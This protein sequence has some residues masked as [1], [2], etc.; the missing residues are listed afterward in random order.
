[1]SSSGSLIGPGVPAAAFNFTP[2]G[3]APASRFLPPTVR[4]VVSTPGKCFLFVILHASVNAPFS[5]KS[6]V[7]WIR[8][9]ALTSL[10]DLR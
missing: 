3:P 5:S 6:L 8:I 2:I 1:M 4:P 9:G 10:Y 7:G